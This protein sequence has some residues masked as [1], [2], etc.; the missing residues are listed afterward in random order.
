M[1]CPLS[2][3]VQMVLQGIQFMLVGM[4]VV[5]TFLAIMVICMYGS[6]KVIAVF[7][8]K[9]PEQELTQEAKTESVISKRNKVALAIAAAYAAAKA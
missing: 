4:G 9:Y 8:R 5:F 6:A 3:G 2:S 7:N 1:L